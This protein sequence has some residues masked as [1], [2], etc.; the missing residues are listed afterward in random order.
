MSTTATRNHEYNVITPLARFENLRKLVPMLEAQGIQWHVIT[1]DDLPFTLCFRKEWIHHYVCPNRETT[2]FT[3]CNWAINWFLDSYP[4]E[5]EQ[6]YC[7]LND[8]DAYEPGFFEKI[9]QHE[10]EVIIPSMER[11]NRTP[12]GVQAERAHGFT[13]LVAAPENMHIGGVS[14]E[15]IV[16]S[17][18]FLRG[19]RLPI[20]IC[21][22]GMMIE[23]F[24]KTHGAEYAPEAN[25]WFNYYEPGRWDK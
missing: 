11:G 18:R 5:L 7:I 2:F 23:W 6:R 10:G 8:D 12:A 24:V 17:G 22:D 9:D 25:V 4:P 3:R 14:V 21:G 1:D 16:V 20:H 13:K 19:A 15:Q